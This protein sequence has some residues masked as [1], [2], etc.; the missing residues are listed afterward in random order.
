MV[1]KE[2]ADVI[3]C[4]VPHVRALIRD[5]KLKAKKVPL[6]HGGGFYYEIKPTEVERYKNLPPSRGYPRGK[7]RKE[8]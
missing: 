5:G 8:K 4:S 3:G 7:K 2:A 6:E 1:P